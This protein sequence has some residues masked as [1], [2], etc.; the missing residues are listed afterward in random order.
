MIP[1]GQFW[2]I[3]TG[4]T[5]NFQELFVHPQIRI[6]LM[7]GTWMFRF[8]RRARILTGGVTGSR[9]DTKN[10]FLSEASMDFVKCSRKD[11]KTKLAILEK[12]FERFTGYLVDGGK[13]TMVSGLVRLM[14]PL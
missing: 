13:I 6:R 1:H 11:G 12:S 14:E 4:V 8:T 2:N 9:M 3:E 5:R 7:R 10:P